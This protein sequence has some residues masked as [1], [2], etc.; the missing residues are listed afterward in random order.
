MQFLKM[1]G[2]GILYAL[3]FPFFLV[4][5]A[6]FAVYGIMNFFIE[7]IIMLINF[8]KGKK[9]FAPYP[10]DEKAFAILQQLQQAQL[11]AMNPKPA[12]T[13]VYVQQNYYP[14]HGH[15]PLGGTPTPLNGAP[16]NQGRL[17]Q[18]QPYGPNEQIEPRSAFD[19]GHPIEITNQP[20]DPTS[21]IEPRTEEKK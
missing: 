8:F 9:L 21:I 6:L 20:A 18:Q 19:A 5:L 15:Q 1:F 14:P 17:S 7:F 3:L 4:I 10:E 11:N 12:T 16:I 13:N 2:L